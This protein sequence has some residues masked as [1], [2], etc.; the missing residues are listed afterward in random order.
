M[1]ICGNDVTVHEIIYSIYFTLI[2]TIPHMRAQAVSK[3]V[4]E[5]LSKIVFLEIPLGIR[6]SLKAESK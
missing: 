4:L 6:S 2:H 3:N 1:K 5:K